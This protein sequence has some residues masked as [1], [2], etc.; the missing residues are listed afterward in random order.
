MS[1]HPPDTGQRGM[2]EAHE[3]LENE[4]RQLQQRKHEKSKNRNAIFKL[5]LPDDCEKKCQIFPEKSALEL[6]WRKLGHRMIRKRRK[7][8]E[9]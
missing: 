5:F 6:L 4:L 2:L 7:C 9:K 8:K 1:T 3:S